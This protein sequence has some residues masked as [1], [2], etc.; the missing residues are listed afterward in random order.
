M[1]NGQL[2]LDCGNNPFSTTGQLQLLI[3]AS[4][5]AVE[6]PKLTTNLKQELTRQHVPQ[7][8]QQIASLRR[9][10]KSFY[11]ALSPSTLPSPSLCS[12]KPAL[13]SLHHDM[14]RLILGWSIQSMGFSLL[15]G[16]E[17]IP[18]LN[19]AKH[20][21]SCLVADYKA[22]PKQ[23]AVLQKTNGSYI[24]FV[25]PTPNET[26][27]RICMGLWAEKVKQLLPIEA[28]SVSAH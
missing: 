9:V 20:S 16:K 26:K 1:G 6:Q 23:K 27:Q 21:F 17:P 15:A 14:V 28:K 10:C 2:K 24:N 22:L 13:P 4:N 12:T 7:T 25:Y 19:I 8:L 5:N 18:T 3:L 11:H